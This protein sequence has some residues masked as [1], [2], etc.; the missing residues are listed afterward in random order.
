MI[1]KP[2]LPLLILLGFLCIRPVAA[3]PEQGNSRKRVGVVFS[4]GSAYGFAH[5]GVLKWME[6]N[7]IPV[8][9]IAGTS[10]GALIG[11][12]YATGMSEAEMEQQLSLIDWDDLFRSS[13]P[14]RLRTFRRKEDARDFQNDIEFGKGFASSTGL[15]S[16][17]SVGLLLSRLTLPYPDDISFDD[18]PIPFRC[19]S[20]ELN[21]AKITR[22]SQGS[23]SQAMRASISIPLVFTTVDEDGRSYVDGGVFENLPVSTM[24]PGPDQPTT[25]KPDAVV[26]IRLTDEGDSSRSRADVKAASEA[27]LGSRNSS[28]PSNV[29]DVVSR[30]I[31]AVTAENMNRSMEALQNTPGLISIPLVVRLKGIS[32]DDFSHWRVAMAFGEAEA[33]RHRAEFTPFRLSD[34]EWQNYLTQKSRKRRRSMKPALVTVV[35]QDPSRKLDPRLSNYIQTK[36]R[37]YV[38]RD[39]TIGT[40]SNRDSNTR[41]L[42]HDLDDLMGTGIFESISYNQMILGGKPALAIRPKEKTY[43]PPFFLA[44]LE[45]DSGDTDN[46]QTTFHVRMNSLGRGLD[47]TDE[48]RTDVYVGSRRELHWE[49]YRPVPVR[50]IFLLPFAYTRKEERS[51]YAAGITGATFSTDETSA[52]IDA[53]LD[54]GRFSQVRAGQQFGHRDYNNHGITI[55]SNDSAGLSATT[56]QYVYDG[57]D[58]PIVAHSGVYGLINGDWYEKAPATSDGYG[59][60]SGEARDAF[61]I[62]HKEVIQATVAGGIQTNGKAPLEEQFTLGGP[63]RMAANFPGELRGESYRFTSIGYLRQLTPRLTLLGGAFQV[64]GWFEQGLVRTDG[65]STRRRDINVAAFAPTHFGPIVIGASIGDAGKKRV[66]IQ[67]GHLL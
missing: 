47:A 22:F 11:G 64:G 46:V 54:L 41:D 23:L 18:L 56:F 27:T 53:G 50:P 2:I 43:G 17:H 10:M 5:L 14:H 12:L 42:N 32:S 20:V 34:T 52:G 1:R 19:T 39:F 24:L 26:T 49:W 37:K 45:I 57:Q 62:S 15:E 29:F 38:G 36:V 35:P 63:F 21:S 25:W 60:V 48:Y 55:L 4:G 31:I 51:I 67:F 8:D 65:Q 7:H 6:K 28:I 59:Q 61:P 16:V 44:N 66:Y 3:Q 13:T 58:D 40:D 30:L 33:E 9:Y